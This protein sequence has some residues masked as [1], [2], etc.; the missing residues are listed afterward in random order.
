M[1]T[2]GNP[3][4]IA[5]RQSS[6]MTRLR[7]NCASV[8]VRSKHFSPTSVQL[9]SEINGAFLCK[10]QQK[11]HLEFCTPCHEPEGREFEFPRARHSTLLNQ[12]VA[13]HFQTPSSS[14]RSCPPDMP[15]LTELGREST[16]F[17]PIVKAVLRAGL[18][19]A[20]ICGAGTAVQGNSS[21]GSC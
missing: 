19:D 2:P 20:H 10:R 6:L 4:L 15:T 12:A 3:Y 7:K 8:R 13:A 14:P 17:K 18:T 5:L 9:K 11:Q 16:D 1:L 21:H